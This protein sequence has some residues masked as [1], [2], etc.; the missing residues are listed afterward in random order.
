MLYL[1]TVQVLTSAQSLLQCP[2]AMRWLEDRE[3]ATALNRR[4]LPNPHHTQL[5]QA[6]LTLVGKGDT[7]KGYE[8]L[9]LLSN[10]NKNNIFVALA[11][12]YRNCVFSSCFGPTK[13][14]TYLLSSVR[15]NSQSSQS[16]TQDRLRGQHPTDGI[17][18][19]KEE[20]MKVQPK[21]QCSSFFPAHKQAMRLE[22]VGATA[23][24]LS[25]L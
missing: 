2:A 4:S 8:K 14:T 1:A 3:A 13:I 25:K 23:R 15:C 18:F 7:I 21:S 24:R 10:Y 16:K 11:L 5:G 12:Y 17:K 19:S 22:A 20:P 6:R 9:W